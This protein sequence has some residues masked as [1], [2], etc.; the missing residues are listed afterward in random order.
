MAEEGTE[1]TNTGDRSPVG[2]LESPDAVLAAVGHRRV[3]R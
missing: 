1:D 3:S 2:G